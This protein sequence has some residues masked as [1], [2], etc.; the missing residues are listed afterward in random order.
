MSFNFLRIKM[1]MNIK[2]FEYFSKKA[3]NFIEIKSIF[4]T[5]D[6]KNILV[7]EGELNG[8]LKKKINKEFFGKWIAQEMNAEEFKEY[9]FRYNTKKFIQKFS[10]GDLVLI[11]EENFKKEIAII[12]NINEEKK[13]VELELKNLF[14]LPLTLKINK[15]KLIKKNEGGEI[16]N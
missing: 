14:N 2:N 10:I 5:E 9:L 8:E 6:L 12:K 16:V 7:F 1:K 3:T 15:I 13:E 4:Y 11:N